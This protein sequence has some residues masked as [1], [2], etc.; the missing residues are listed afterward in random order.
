MKLETRNKKSWFNHPRLFGSPSRFKT[1][2]GFTMIDLLV[3]IGIFSVVVSIA[4][5]GFVNAMR[6]QRQISAII[7]ANN[8]VVLA[9]EQMAREIRT[10]FYFCSPNVAYDP[11]SPGTFGCPNYPNE[12]RFINTNGQAVRYSLSAGG[13]I[14]KDTTDLNTSLTTSAQITGSNA[15]IQ[16]LSFV[17]RGNNPGDLLQSRITVVIGVSAKAIGVSGNVVSLQTTISARQLDG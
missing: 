15:A 10:G 12:I 8:N 4:A 13:T 14:Q 16:Y 9:L 6:T 1:Q 5:G 2:E 17:I 3:A 11:T 7:A